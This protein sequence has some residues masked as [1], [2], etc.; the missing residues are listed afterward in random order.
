MCL[1]HPVFSVVKLL[2]APVDPIP[3]RHPAPLPD[4]VVV[5][6]EPQYE[7]EAV[8]NSCLYRHRLQFLVAWKGYG[9]EENSWVDERDINA[10]QLINEFY[11]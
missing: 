3:R 7:L 4:P 8:L 9:R 2:R 6:G 10:L 11:R 1:L 5:E